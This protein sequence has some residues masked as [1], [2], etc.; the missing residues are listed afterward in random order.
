MATDHWRVS[1]DGY[2]LKLWGVPKA[3][4]GIAEDLLDEYTELR[5]YEAA[6]V[7]GEN[8]GLQ[9]SKNTLHHRQ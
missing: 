1:F 4:Y 5:P 6:L 7:F 3:S 2:V 9:R 8:H